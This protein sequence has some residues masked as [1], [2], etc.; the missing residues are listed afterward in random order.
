MSSKK[1][2]LKKS[3]LY[4]IVDKKVTGP[5]A[6]FEI[7]KKARDSA[8]GVIQFR[9]KESAKSA[10]LEDAYR[11]RKLLSNSQTIFIINDYLDIA[12][13]VGSDGVHLGQND[14]SPEITRQILGKDKII[15]VSCH[16]LNQAQEA[17]NKRADYISLGPVFPTAIKPEYK[18]TGLNLIKKANETIHIPFFAIG[19]IN[20]SN[21]NLVLSLG[22][23][24]AAICRAVCQAKN[25]PLAIQKLSKAVTYGT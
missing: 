7:V 8:V 3:H 4:L 2:L 6:I 17:Q 10:I 11:I 12:R 1:Q 18:P 14:T 19:G 23:K 22:A 9:D 20:E 5:R 24:R 25:I 16:N 13:I 21:I 15:G